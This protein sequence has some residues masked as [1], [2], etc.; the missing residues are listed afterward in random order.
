MRA[1]IVERRLPER[2]QSSSALERVGDFY[3]VVGDDSA[4]LLR[5]NAQ[6]EVAGSTPLFERAGPQNGRIAKDAKPDLEAM[7]CVEWQAQREL[8]CFGSG[9]KAPAR[10]VCFR[11]DVT[12]PA[13]PGNVRAV[14]LTSLYDALRADPRIVG[15]NTLNIEAA[16]AA[17]DKI[18]L[19]QRGNISGINAVIEFGAVEL[20]KYLQDP[21]ISPPAPRI[22][23]Y[24]LPQIG[25]RRAGFSAAC[26]WNEGI[27]F[28]ASVEDTDNEIEDG[29]TLG[30]FV[31]FLASQAVQWICGV[32][33]GDGMMP[34]KIEG[35]SPG[36]SGGKGLRVFALTDN[37]EGASELLEIEI[38]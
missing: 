20:L 24:T 6:W 15:R 18:L 23:T 8:W 16:A 38:A 28:A 30:S 17:R 2:L 27:L 36:E 19:F 25:T 37:D 10:D 12:D 35:I 9:S 22:E 7:C 31:G 4:E 29:A 33:G 1:R 14:P 13:A 34:V 21:A 5:L 11:V 3:F 32:E 26:A